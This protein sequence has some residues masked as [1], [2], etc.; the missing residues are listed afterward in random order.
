MRPRQWIKNGFVLAPMVFAM[1]RSPELWIKALIAMATFI[2]ISSAVY[3]LN[4]IVDRAADRLHPVKRN[5]PIASGRV[6]VRMAGIWMGLLVLAGMVLALRLPAACLG[7]LLIYGGL[8][9]AYSFYLKHQVILD[10]LT[11]AAGFVLRVV[12]GGY[13][14]GTQVSPWIIMATFALAL[15]LGFGKRR[16]ELVA[17]GD[18]APRASLADYNAALLDKFITLSCTSAF[19]LYAVYAVEMEGRTGSTGLVYTVGFVAYGLFRYLRYIYV[20]ANGERPEM[21]LARD[22]PFVING[23]A[24][25]ACTLWLLS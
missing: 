5:R 19:L 25:L 2:L 9:I 20:E 1:E 13:A 17:L 16:Q 6:S 21:I 14:T 4:D 18:A 8:N 7:V 24:W 12:M 11:I 22:I 10:V 15:F 3:V 23:I